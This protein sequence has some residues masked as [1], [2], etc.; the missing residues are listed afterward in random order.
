MLTCSRVSD[1]PRAG[2]P[3]QDGPI[4]TITL[5]EANAGSTQLTATHSRRAGADED[6]AGIADAWDQA[7]DKLAA[8]YGR[9]Q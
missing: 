9:R 2:D 1:S 3:P 6:S 5:R 8:L 7:L 4:V